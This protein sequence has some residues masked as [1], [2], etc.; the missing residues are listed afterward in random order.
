MS[1]VGDAL[2]KVKYL[3]E[4]CVYLFYVEI[5]SQSLEDSQ[6]GYILQ[7]NTL[8]SIS[9]HWLV[10]WKVSRTDGRTDQPTN[11]GPTD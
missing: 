2:Q 3:Q 11:F 8:E 10:S 5:N 6:V 9:F 1:L 7:K 4:A